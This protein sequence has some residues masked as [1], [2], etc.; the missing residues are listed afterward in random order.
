M[1]QENPFESFQKNYKIGDILETK[2][3]SKNDYSLFVRVDGF[4]DLDIF[5][6]ANNLSYTTNNRRR[7][8]KI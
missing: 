4:E 3:V 2:I 7:V 1:T 6:H 5:V 8:S